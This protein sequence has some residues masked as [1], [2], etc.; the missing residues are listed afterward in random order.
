[1]Q[2]IFTKLCSLVNVEKK[3][4]M[5]EKEENKQKLLLKTKL[6]LQQENTRNF[7]LMSRKLISRSQRQQEATKRR[8][9]KAEVKGL[10]KS[11]SAHHLSLPIR[12]DDLSSSPGSDCSSDNLNST[13]SG[14]MSLDSGVSLECPGL[15]LAWE[16]RDPDRDCSNF[17]PIARA[18]E[19]FEALDVDGDGVVTEEEFINGC[20]KDQAFVMLLEKFSGDTIWGL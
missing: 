17:D 20:L 4:E 9:K 3:I 13:R 19:L 10:P 8:P 2:E 18:Q 12:E 15:S 5:K 16:L 11:K 6:K 7:Q 14:R 1:M